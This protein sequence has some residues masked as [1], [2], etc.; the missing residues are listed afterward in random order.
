[1]ARRKRKNRAPEKNTRLEDFGYTV[2]TIDISRKEEVIF[3]RIYDEIEEIDF[4]PKKRVK[5]GD[6]P[7]GDENGDLTEARGQEPIRPHLPRREIRLEDFKPIPQGQIPVKATSDPAAA[8]GLFQKLHIETRD[9]ILRYLLVWPHEIPVF[10]GWSLVYPRKRPS[11][12]PPILCTCKKLRDQGLKILFG[13]NTFVYN[14][15]DPLQDWR[16]DSTLL[17]I[18]ADC[19][20]PI[21]EHGHLIREVKIKV[22]RS[23]LHFIGHRRGFQNAIRKFLPGGG[24]VH[25]KKLNLNTLTIEVPA[26]SKRD[27]QWVCDED[28]LD[29]VPICR[30]LQTGS[31]FHNALQ[32]L[33]VPWVRVIAWDGDQQC[34]ETIFD[35]RY[36]VQDARMKEDLCQRQQV[37]I[38]EGA[39]DQNAPNASTAAAAEPKSK[40]IEAVEK[41][42][43][44]R[45][46]RE[47]AELR[48]LAWRVEMLAIRPEIVVG[49]LQLWRPV[50]AEP[51]DDAD[52]ELLSLPVSRTRSKNAGAVGAAGAAGIARNELVEI[53]DEEELEVEELGEGGEM[54]E[55]EVMEGNMR[56]EEDMVEGAMA[57]GVMAE[58]QPAEEVSVA[59]AMLEGELVVET[60]AEGEPAG[61]G[62]MPKEGDLTEARMITE[63]ESMLEED[64]VMEG[65]MTKGGDITTKRDM[66]GEGESTGQGHIAKEG[67]AVE[68]DMLEWEAELLAGWEDMLTEGDMAKGGDITTKG[69]MPGEEEST[70]Q[71]HIAKE[72]DAV[73]EDMLEWEAELL[74]GWENM[75]TEGDMANER[76]MARVPVEGEL[77][78]WE[79]QLEVELA[80]WRDMTQTAEA[81]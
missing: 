13:E 74:A 22:H 75:L 64:R 17:N 71:G 40:E 31:T 12:H 26:E 20:V 41:Q 76:D 28:R 46:D 43:Q 54:I 50:V 25:D 73:E 52:D 42:W 35:R 16:R 37:E 67:D 57:H 10:H 4:M 34:W 56:G 81:I 62:D 5:L 48:E 19:I 79:A 7:N 30:Y 66:P 59:G 9:Q 32:K 47:V 70:G 72:G 77:A 53:L 33:I 8:M 61:K 6:E 68:E 2:R 60:M 21:N 36:S 38:T 11:L 44:A 39:A 51:N 23:R 45:V 24:L 1:M 78:D 15:R 80:C 29:D 65:D 18:L 55:G 14:L 49:D 27:L 69:D 63:Q 58:G 3:P